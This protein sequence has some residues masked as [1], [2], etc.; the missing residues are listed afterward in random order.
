MREGK[1]LLHLLSS[2]QRTC[3]HL[4]VSL[5]LAAPQPLCIASLRCFIRIWRGPDLPFFVVVASYDG[6]DKRTC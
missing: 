1:Q 4:A 5:P 2:R 6:A 3:L